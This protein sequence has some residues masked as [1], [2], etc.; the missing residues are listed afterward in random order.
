MTAE[1]RNQT[2]EQNTRGYAINQLGDISVATGARFELGDQHYYA[3][4]DPEKEEI[5]RMLE[6]LSYP[7]IL[8]KTNCL[9]A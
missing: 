1:R 4:G 5:S 3:Q 2:S 6:A 7:E 9:V 8:S